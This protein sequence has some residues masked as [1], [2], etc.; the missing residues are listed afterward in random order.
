MYSAEDAIAGSTSA[1][2]GAVHGKIY[3]KG[4]NR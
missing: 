2:G 4:M 3:K 1:A